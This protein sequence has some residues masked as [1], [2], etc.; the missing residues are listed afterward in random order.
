MVKRTVESYLEQLGYDY[1]LLGKE[2]SPID[3][4]APIDKG[5]FNHLSFCSSDD[6]EGLQ[7]ILSSSSGTILCK[8]SLAERIHQKN[9]F[10]SNS[11][12]KLYVFVD[13]PR[14][15][16]IKIVKLMKDHND[17]REGI[18]KHA[19]IAD[20]AKIGR[21]SYLGD[22]AIVGEECIVGENTIIDS[23]VVLKNT[24]VG[25]N[26]TL[27]SGCIIGEDG[28][29]FERDKK[30]MKLEKFPHY[31]KVIIENDVEIFTNCSI[32]RGSITNTVVEEGTKI[33]A[34]CHIAHNVHI[35]KNAQITAGVVVGGSTIIG[36]N[37]WLGLNSTI[38]HKLKIGNSVIVG[39]GSSV[40]HN[41]EDK[42]IVAGN[43]A[44]S[45]KYKISISDDK[46]FLMGGQSNEN[47]NK[48]HRFM[49]RKKDYSI[50]LKGL[51]YLNILIGTFL[52]TI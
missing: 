29:A 9:K 24:I 21:N 3:S 49:L 48:E 42:D 5:T 28:F 38:K 35:G 37:C 14:L 13:N 47:R 26:C 39:S 32:A 34:L 25:N 19:I 27:Q 7:S 46:L 16:F 30:D 45:I 1:T 52:T 4:V 18:S 31:G 40:I 50:R 41:V 6:Y 11:I 43:P 8:K 33:D 17:N 15:V 2:R 51:T 12:P 10:F 36:N 20:S 23:R 44:K 22:L